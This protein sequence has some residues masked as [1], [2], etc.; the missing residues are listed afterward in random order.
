MYVA[1]SAALHIDH[2]SQHILDHAPIRALEH[3]HKLNCS[4]DYNIDRLPT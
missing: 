4:C 2:E 3:Y 1:I